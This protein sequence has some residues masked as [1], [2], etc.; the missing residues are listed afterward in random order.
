MRD[1]AAHGWANFFVHIPVRAGPRCGRYMSYR[2]ATTAIRG[3]R[4]LP[5]RSA[6]SRERAVRGTRAGVVP[7]RERQLTHKSRAWR[8]QESA[9]HTRSHGPVGRVSGLWSHVQA[10]LPQ[11]LRIGKTVVARIRLWWAIAT[12][13]PSF[14]RGVERRL[15]DVPL[16]HKT[17]GARKTESR[18]SKRTK[19]PGAAT[20]L[21]S[22]FRA[23][24]RS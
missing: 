20:R 24:P 3:S 21:N 2:I 17:K 22:L 1:L 4:E 8:A 19:K 14:M 7:A 15:D 12:M 5:A 16:K 13:A 9:T 18:D 10:A 6:R 23:V 11:Q